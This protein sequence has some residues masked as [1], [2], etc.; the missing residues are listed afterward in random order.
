MAAPAEQSRILQASAIPYRR[1][2]KDLEFCLVTSVKKRR[3]GFP[4]GIIDPG[5]TPEETALKEADEEA[6]LAGAIEGPPLGEY[7][8]A[9]WGTTL[10]VAVYL[11]R[12]SSAAE[13]WAEREMRER[14]WVS[15]QEAQRRLD[16]DELRRLVDAALARLQ[17]EG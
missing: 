6:G 12:V 9:K 10:N 3:W 5:E 2:G 16:R 15:A 1:N 4:K 11:M 14:A 13:D 17:A 7:A 8:Y